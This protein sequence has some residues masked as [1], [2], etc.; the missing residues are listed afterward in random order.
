MT[1]T[2]LRTYTPEFRSEA[3]KLVLEQGLS[4]E[5]T[6]QRLSKKRPPRTSLGS[7]CPVRAIEDDATRVP[8]CAAMPRFRRV[9]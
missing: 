8:G 9:A 7:R 3:V 2:N 6:A 5:A 4:L 1:R